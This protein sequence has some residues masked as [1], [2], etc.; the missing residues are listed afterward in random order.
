MGDGAAGAGLGHGQ[1]LV[2]LGQFADHDQFQRVVV[3]AEDGFS[4]LVPDHLA[5]FLRELERAGTPGDDADV[6]RAVMGA[7]A[8]LDAPVLER[9]QP[10]LHPLGQGRFPQARRAPRRAGHFGFQRALGAQQWD[11]LFGEHGPKFARRSGQHEEPGRRGGERIGRHFH[12]EAGRGAVGIVEDEGAFGGEG[13]DLVVRRHGPVSGA[14]EF[15]DLA[16]HPLVQHQ[17]PPE[18]F[19]DELPGDV[20][21][22]GSEPAGD[23]DDAGTAEGFADRLLDVRAGVGHG[24]LADE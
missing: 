23:D 16:E 19:G 21:G 7:V 6:D 13:L 9:G 22:R 20:V 4:Q 12:R 17:L 3:P 2:P 1:G 11:D 14:E 10:L 18:Q 8:E 15:P 24:D 5:G